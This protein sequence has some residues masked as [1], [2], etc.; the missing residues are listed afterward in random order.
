MNN[1][2]LENG[3]PVNSIQV[4]DGIVLINIFT[5]DPAKAAQF[6]STQIGEYKRLQGQFPGNYTANLHIS[7]DRTHAANYAHFASVED[8][9]VMRN[10]TEFANHLTC[11]QG[12]VVKAEPQLYQVVY[13]QRFDM[14]TS[15]EPLPMLPNPELAPKLAPPA[16]S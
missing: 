8:Y 16:L 9:V 1:L 2:H 3:F 10:S 6:V 14:P 5:L 15:E 11:L 12:L 7:L 4:G 13:T